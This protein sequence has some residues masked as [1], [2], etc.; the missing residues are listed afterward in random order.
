MEAWKSRLPRT[1][2]DW[3][4]GWTFIEPYFADLPPGH[5]TLELLDEW[6]ARLMRAKGIDVAYRA[7]KTWRALYNVMAG[8]KLCTPK[9]D[10]SLAIRRKTPNRRTQVWSEGEAVRLVKG[11][12]RAGYR[13]L[14]C[15]IAVAWD[16]SFSPVDVRT[17]TPAQAV[18][19]AQEWGFLIERTKSGE[20]AFGTLSPRTQRLV[21]AY[22]ESLG[23]TLLDDAPIFR[24]RG[25]ARAPRAADRAPAC[26]TR[27]TR[28]STTSPNCAGW[29]SGK[30][31]SVAS[32]TCGDPARSRPM[33]AALP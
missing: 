18:K 20:A 27:R 26:L 29:F 10:P 31:R 3:E 25:F 5:I 16:T 22:V 24:S 32:W 23:V 14:A 2:E 4:R 11:A 8:M 15:I 19:T 17:L 12:W 13:G 6:Y 21:L 9:A 28:W 7:M 1:R 33:P 30:G